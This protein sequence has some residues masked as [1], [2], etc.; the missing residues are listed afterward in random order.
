MCIYYCSNLSHQVLI[1]LLYMSETWHACIKKKYWFDASYSVCSPLRIKIRAGSSDAAK[2]IF[3]FF[4]N[5]AFQIGCS[6]VEKRTLAGVTTTVRK[7]S[8]LDFLLK[9]YQVGLVCVITWDHIV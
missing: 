2:I 3:T 4:R 9:N 8:R 6:R 5:F 7:N 1:L